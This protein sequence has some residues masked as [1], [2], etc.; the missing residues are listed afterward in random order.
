L[1]RHHFLSSA[2]VDGEAAGAACDPLRPERASIGELYRSPV[3]TGDFGPKQLFFMLF[4]R[5]GTPT[6][7]VAASGTASYP[8]HQ[9]ELMLNRLSSVAAAAGLCALSVSASATTF[10]PFKVNETVVPGANVFSLAN[11]NLS[12]DK[13]NGSYSE[14]L[15]IT[16]PTTFA[17]VA[18]ANFS[19]FLT[20]DGTTPVTSLLNSF[21]PIGGYKIY[22]IFGSTGTVTGTSFSST[23]NYFNLYLDSGSDTVLTLPGDA[24]LPIGVAGN[25]EDQLLASAMTSFGSGDT[26]GPPGAF[27]IDFTD[28]TL[29]AL[30]TS[31]F[32][33]PNPFYMNVRVNGDID[34]FGL[35][36]PTSGNGD[37]DGLAPFVGPSA[38]ITGDVSAGFVVIP[39]PMSLALVG[40]ALLGVGA[41]R[42]KA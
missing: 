42:R 38:R 12:A 26:V 10:Q 14:V 7:E 25:G 35:V 34:G 5:F 21:D 29:T 19:Q 32:F 1:Q 36:A 27:N 4:T 40:L 31:Y 22:A 13:L 28:F 37:I 20:G 2:W 3:E 24:L 15:T 23:S 6:A 16:G 11:A 30:G 41:L 8:A 18:F 17:S 33:A 9:E 39:E